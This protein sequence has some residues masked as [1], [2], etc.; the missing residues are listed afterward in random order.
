MTHMNESHFDRL[1]AL[2]LLGAKSCL[3]DEVKSFMEM[4]DT[5]VVNEKART[6]AWRLISRQ[7]RRMR[8]K[9]MLRPMKIAAVACLTVLSVL[10]TACVCIPKVRDAMWQAIVEWYDEYIAIGFRKNVQDEALA[11]PPKE[12]EAIHAPTYMPDGYSSVSEKSTISYYQEYY[13]AEGEFAFFFI[14]GL[15]DKEIIEIDHTS[16][17]ASV[18]DIHGTEGVLTVDEDGTMGLTW[19]DQQYSYI[20]HGRFASQAE[21]LAIAESVPCLR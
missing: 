9:G 6:R 14:Q 10:F 11:E 5:G 18:I 13:T 3:A 7:Q 2:I 1:D 12:I 21:L 16:D 8:A 4:E 15:R 19:Q 20:L 17:G